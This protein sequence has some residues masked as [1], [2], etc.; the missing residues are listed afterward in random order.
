MEKYIYL[1]NGFHFM[2]PFSSARALN[3][4]LLIFYKLQI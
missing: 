1:K 3:E 4:H 2:V